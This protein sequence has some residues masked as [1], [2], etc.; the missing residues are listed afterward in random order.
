MC[1]AKC[2]YPGKTITFHVDA[3]SNPNYFAALVEY[4]DGDGDLAAMDLKQAVNSDTWLPMQES[5]GAVWKLNSGSALKA[6]FSI[7][8]TAL[9]SGNTI[10]ANNVI[11][12][13]WQPGQSYRSIVNFAT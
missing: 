1:R 11:P 2:N 12:D 10:V 6:P 7:R 13:G 8:L 5:W 4:E 9:E 3:G